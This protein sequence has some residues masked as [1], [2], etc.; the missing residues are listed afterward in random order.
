MRHLI[1]LLIALVCAAPAF[2]QEVVVPSDR[3]TTHV[4]IR[5]AP[6]ADSMEIGQLG[7][8]QSLPRIQ[9]VLRWYEIRLPDGR[10]GFVAK[11]WTILTQLL[12]PRKKDELRIHFLRA[13]GCGSLRPYR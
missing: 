11:S 2:A 12:A 13:R 9:S 4:N 6:D 3:V 8:D 5:A 1:L 10:S 7:I